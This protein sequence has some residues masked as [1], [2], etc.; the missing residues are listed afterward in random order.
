[1]TTRKIAEA[2][3]RDQLIK[4]VRERFAGETAGL[5]CRMVEE[6]PHRNQLWNVRT[7]KAKFSH[8]LTLVRQN[9]PQFVQREGDEEPVILLSLKAMHDLLERGV[10]GQ[11]FTERMAPFMQRTST[12]LTAP[13]LG[14]MDRFEIPD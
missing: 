1:M 3:T 9:E 6:L 4:I 13:E 2:L 10:N 7:A 14:E 8:V 12:I 5:M 11:S